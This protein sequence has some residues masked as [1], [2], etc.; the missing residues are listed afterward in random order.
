MRTLRRR[1][2]R[3]R[4]GRHPRGQTLVEFALVFPLFIILLTGVIEFA[5]MFNA[6]LAVN[7]ASRN[8]AL[9]AAESGMN[10][11][12]DCAILA[13]IEQ[14]IAA[15]LDKSTG[16]Q[17]VT[18]FKADRVG[19]PVSA[20]AANVYSRTGTTACASFTPSPMPYS[21]VGGSQGYPMGPAPGPPGGRCALL[22]GCSST[23]PMDSIGVKI[24]YRYY[25]HT[26]VRNLVNF[27]PGA[28]GGYIDF[29][30]SSV[31]RMEPIL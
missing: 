29:T 19:N 13:Q 5:F 22:T 10:M 3:P 28:T 11:T 16:I 1:H 24:V 31:M 23:I 20:S 27:L 18:I 4:L 26:P 30:W 8:A 6:T 21:L 7:F 12:A 14:D 2:L 25:F 9:I 15:P 17:S